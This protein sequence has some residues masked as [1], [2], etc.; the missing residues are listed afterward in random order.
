[1]SECFSFSSH[2]SHTINLLLINIWLD[3]K[4]APSLSPKVILKKDK[5]GTQDGFW[6]TW[7]FHTSLKYFKLGLWNVFLFIFK[8]IRISEAD[9]LKLPIS[10]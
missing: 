10:N 9:Q 4:V 5:L 7:Q 2:H 1:M 3:L 6:G 8:E